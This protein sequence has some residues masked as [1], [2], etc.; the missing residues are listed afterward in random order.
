MNPDFT[1]RSPLPKVTDE[2]GSAKAAVLAELRRRM[3]EEPSSTANVT[4]GDFSFV[5]MPAPAGGGAKKRARDEDE[6][7]GQTGE[8]TSATSIT[9]KFDKVHRKQ[10]DKYVFHDSL[11]RTFEMNS[12]YT[13]CVLQDGVNR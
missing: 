1:F 5:A 2:K 10:F 12:Y 3:A 4:L 7:A 13:V 6:E 8:D 9:A 11:S